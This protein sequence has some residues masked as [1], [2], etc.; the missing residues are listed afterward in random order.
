MQDLASVF[1]N[2]R[3]FVVCGGGFYLF[4]LNSASHSHED[5]YLQDKLLSMAYLESNAMTGW[6][7]TVYHFYIAS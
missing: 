4:N 7:S 6:N 5:P 1:R 2:I 3:V